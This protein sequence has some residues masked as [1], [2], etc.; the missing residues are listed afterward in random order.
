MP[1][2][3]DEDNLPAYNRL[4]PAAGDEHALE[5]M[6]ATYWILP[7]KGKIIKLV[8]GDASELEGKTLPSFNRNGNKFVRAAK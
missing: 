1:Q 6:P 5:N 4:K 8:V 2:L 3:D 7:Q